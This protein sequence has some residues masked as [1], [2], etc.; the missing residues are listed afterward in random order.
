MNIFGFGQNLR[1][2]LI[3]RFFRPF[4]F[5]KMSDPFDDHVVENLFMV[6]SA[7]L[8]PPEL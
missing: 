2:F 5:R 4:G 6:Y 8:E 1:G 3:L 7:I